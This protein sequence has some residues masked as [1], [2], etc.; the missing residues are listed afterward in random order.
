[1]HDSLGSFDAIW[2][3][4]RKRFESKFAARLPVNPAIV[5]SP[6]LRFQIGREMLREEG[7]LRW[8]CDPVNIASLVARLPTPDSQTDTT[9]SGVA[10]VGVSEV[11]VSGDRTNTRC[12]DHT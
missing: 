4:H 9:I 11:T 5:D 3:E 2:E 6:V 12:R 10:D 8:L 1:M 7:Q